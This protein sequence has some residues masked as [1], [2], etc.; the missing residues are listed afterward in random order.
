MSTLA[1]WHTFDPQECDECLNSPPPEDNRLV[2]HTNWN[3]DGL[4]VASDG[5]T[6]R[7]V[8]LDLSL[9]RTGVA[10]ETG[11][12]SVSVRIDRHAS[13][14]QRVMRLRSVGKLL[15]DIC[16]DADLVIYEGV[17]HEARYQS[18][19][20][21]ELHGVIKLLLYQAGVPFV[22]IPPKRLKKYATDN[23]NAGKDE[24]LAAAI[25]W[26]SP[27]SN[28]DEADAW[29][30]RHIALAHYLGKDDVLPRYRQRVLGSITG[31]PDLRERVEAV[32]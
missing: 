29:W 15:R 22:P 19:A 3:G 18:H 16:M 7:I 32:G 12:S 10:D 11:T 24:M 13:D 25:H 9:T 20:L 2:C 17:A 26:G 28:N 6:R 4:L 27:A 1:G 5:S 23:G 30:L 21:G 8:G 31:W 14:L